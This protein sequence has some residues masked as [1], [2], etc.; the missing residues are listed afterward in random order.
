MKGEKGKIHAKITISFRSFQYRIVIDTKKIEERQAVSSWDRQTTGGERI[1][2]EMFDN[3]KRKVK[4]AMSYEGL[5]EHN[6]LSTLKQI[7]ILIETNP[8]FAKVVRKH[9]KGEV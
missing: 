7:E 6:L 3:M 2:G 4:Q 8:E 5:K 1:E 9:I